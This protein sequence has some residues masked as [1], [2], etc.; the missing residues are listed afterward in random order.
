MLF[1][2][3]LG[4]IGI[5]HFGGAYLWRSLVPPIEAVPLRLL[6]AN[7]ADAPIRLLTLKLGAEQNTLDF[8]LPPKNAHGSFLFDFAQRTYVEQVEV[9]YRSGDSA[10][11]KRASL[12]TDA[13]RHGECE[14]HVSFGK[15]I[16]KTVNVSECERIE[17][18]DSVP[19]DPVENGPGG[20]PK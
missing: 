3:A 9:V 7:E 16:G 6:F 12:T 10:E 15:D 19:W 1:A 8:D 17:D 2:I 14:I 13:R 18:A 11:S 20:S 4:F 5:W